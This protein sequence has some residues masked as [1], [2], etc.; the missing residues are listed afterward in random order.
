MNLKQGGGFARTYPLGTAVAAVVGACDGELSIG[1]ICAA[2]S[3]LLEVDE[4]ELLAEV[5]PTIREFVTVGI[6]GRGDAT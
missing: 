1:A 6:L 2:V 5:L 3:E 4:S